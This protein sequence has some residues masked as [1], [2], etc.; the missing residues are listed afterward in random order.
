MFLQLFKKNECKR[1]RLLIKM[2]NMNSAANLQKQILNLKRRLHSPKT[3]LF[4]N[5]DNYIVRMELPVR[6][7]SW[8]LKDDQILLVSFD[9]QRDFLS[10]VTTLYSETK[11]GKTMRRVKLPNKVHSNP[12][13]NE[14]E[15]GI[16]IIEFASQPNQATSQSIRKLESIPEEWA[17]DI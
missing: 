15:N 2:Y 9:K 11:Y 13:R 6:D 12:I 17:D 14:W 8:E 1:Q 16:L 5:G 3:D 10:H 7:F 4:V